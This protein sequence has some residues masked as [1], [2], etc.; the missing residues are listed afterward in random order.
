MRGVRNYTGAMSTRFF[1]ST[2][3]VEELSRSAIRVVAGVRLWAMMRRMGWCP[4]RAL[5]EQLGSGRAAAHLMLWME[6]IGAAWPEAFCVSPPCSP[7]LSHDEATVGEM[8]G[9]AETANRPG[10][11]R[12]LADMLPAD[13]RERLFTSARVLSRALG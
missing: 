10:F 12:L 13:E 4:M 6:E 11:D 9:L 8:I 5:A 2:R 3:E 1:T 7:R